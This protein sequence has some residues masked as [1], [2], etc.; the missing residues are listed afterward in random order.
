MLE[1]DSPWLAWGRPAPAGNASVNGFCST[2]SVLL[3]RSRPQRGI[4]G[5][6]L[7]A[8]ARAV[9]VSPPAL[10]RYFAGRDGLVRALHGDLTAERSLRRSCRTATGR[11]RPQRPAA[12]RH[13]RRLRL[14]GLPTARHSIG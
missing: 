3:V 9:G 6:T 7:A 11:R 10:Y 1:G 5:L 12:C 8:V 14:V 4:H 2:H 13:P